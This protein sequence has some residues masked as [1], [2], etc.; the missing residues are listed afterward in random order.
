[1]TV[2]PND[3]GSG[4]WVEKWRSPK[5]GKWVHKY[6]L[7]FIAARA[8]QKFADNVHVGRQLPAIR[9][10]LAADIKKDGTPEQALALIVTLIDNAY[11]RV[12]N[13]TSDDNGVHG[14]TTLEKR[15][16]TV[17]RNRATFDYVGKKKVTQHRIVTDNVVA[18]LLR[19]L[20]KNAP[21]EDTR[22]FTV[23]GNKIDAG[24]VNDYL[25]AFD[26]TAK[27]FRTFHSTRLVRE[28][29]L[30]RGDVPADAREDVVDAVLQD[31]AE[32]LGHSPAVNRKSYTDPKVIQ[33]FM[34]GRLR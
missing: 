6:T 11:F 18:R 12:G 5:T 9:K 30:A 32:L 23:N 20:K 2:T 7:K 27:Q 13:E 16:V 25:D 26:V 3:T 15:H 17:Y 14:V 34:K 4:N 21:T 8:N 28:K 29:L 1:V 22:L 33:A 24:D 10:M 19:R 31:V